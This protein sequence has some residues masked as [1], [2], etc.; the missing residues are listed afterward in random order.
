MPRG[1]KTAKGA[2]SAKGEREPPVRLGLTAVFTAG[3][4]N[5]GRPR[6]KEG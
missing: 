1:K 4:V 6:A 3:K 5:A 2:K